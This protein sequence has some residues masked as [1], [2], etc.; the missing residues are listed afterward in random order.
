M[1]TLCSLSLL[2][3]AVCGLPAQVPEN[4]E[5]RDRYKEVVLS[6]LRENAAAPAAVLAQ[7]DGSRVLFRIERAGS[8]L[9]TLFLNERGAAFPIDSS[10]S[11]VIKRQL[12]DGGFVQAKVFFRSDPGCF[13]RLF[14]SGNR[15]QMEVFLLGIPV[16]RRVQLPVAFASLLTAPFARIQELS[17]SQVR[18]DL[19]LWRGEPAA[20]RRLEDTIR[21]IRSALGRL[22]EADDGA[23]DEE[24][25][26]V[27]IADGNRQGGGGGLNCSGFAKWIVD[28]FYGPL[29]GGRYLGV[30]ELKL[31]HPELRGN[32]WSERYEQARDPYFGLDWARNLASALGLAY[33]Q[34]VSGPESADVRRLEFLEYREDVGFPVEE[35][36]L[37][38]FL[39]AARHPGSFY[40]GSLNRELAGLPGQPVLRQHY[41]LAVFF[42]FFTTDGEFRV[43][44]FDLTRESSLADMRRRFAGH[45]VHLERLAA[46]G[47]WVAPRE[48]P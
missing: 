4:V 17:R 14:P 38:L 45:F 3:L 37:A 32:R 46:G 22:R 6:T 36:E 30:T 19:L 33:G 39:D 2:L 28:G 34:A 23:M 10:G 41:H 13:V 24:G 35:L 12:E 7:A 43:A 40:L 44:V 5:V 16:G 9:Y 15:T 48:R 27:R 1:R 29:A 8:S 20:D 18:W 25:Y 47:E 42:P 21:R 31:R 26:Y 11:W